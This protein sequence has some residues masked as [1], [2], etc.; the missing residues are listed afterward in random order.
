M[1]YFVQYF[2]N[3]LRSLNIG[4]LLCRSLLLRLLVLLD[5]CLPCGSQFQILWKT[6]LFPYFPGFLLELLNVVIK[7]VIFII[8][9]SR[10]TLKGTPCIQ[11]PLL[12]MSFCLK[13]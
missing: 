9:I 11:L 8:R 1:V 3:Y 10:F 6:I 7:M 13:R 4:F 5:F 2:V 12:G